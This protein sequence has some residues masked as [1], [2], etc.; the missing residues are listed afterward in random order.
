MSHLD[1]LD[2][3]TK[4][5][6]ILRAY[7]Q[8]LSRLF[9]MPTTRDRMLERIH[10]K[11]RGLSNQRRHILDLIDTNPELKATLRHRERA[12]H[13]PPP[14]SDKYVLEA[15]DNLARLLYDERRAKTAYQMGVWYY[16]GG[17]WKA[18][19]LPLDTVTAMVDELK[20][21]S[22]EA[23]SARTTT[24]H[25]FEERVKTSMLFDPAHI[26]ER[27]KLLEAAKERFR[28]SEP[29]LEGPNDFERWHDHQMAERRQ[30]VPVE[31][32]FMDE[33]QPQ[34]RR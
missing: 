28:K 1:D 15:S 12:K 6:E 26:V 25:L 29:K 9:F 7:E 19:A 16:K 11:W 2:R 24:Q 30:A 3:I 34:R 17:D 31:K 10:R 8:R 18:D 23:I 22:T 20:R 27:E 21:R 32:H 14:A 13:A 33:P 4:K 5:L